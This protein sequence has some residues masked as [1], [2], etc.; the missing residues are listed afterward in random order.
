ML[1]KKRVKGKALIL[2]ANGF[3][4]S[5]TDTQLYFLFFFSLSPSQFFSL[6]IYV[7]FPKTLTQGLT[8]SLC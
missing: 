8:L 7:Y 3:F 2:V 1:T 4:Q 6:S 5:S